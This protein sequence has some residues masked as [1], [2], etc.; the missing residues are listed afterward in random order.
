MIV[1]IGYCHE[2]Y[3][4]HENAGDHLDEDLG[5][6]MPNHYCSDWWEFLAAVSTLI[7]YGI[8]NMT[9]QHASII[10]AF[11][12][13]ELDIADSSEKEQ[14]HQKAYLKQNL[15]FMNN[16][17]LERDEDDDPST[18]TTHVHLL[19]AILNGIR[20]HAVSDRMRLASLLDA[21][22]EETDGINADKEQI[23]QSFHTC[24]NVLVDIGERILLQLPSSFVNCQ[25]AG[26][27]ARGL[28]ESYLDR[29]MIDEADSISCYLSQ[30]N[31][32]SELRSVIDPLR[33]ANAI[34]NASAHPLV[35]SHLSTSNTREQI[36]GFR[37]PRD[38]QDLVKGLFRRDLVD[39][40][41]AG[42]GYGDFLCWLHLPIYPEPLLFDYITNF[43]QE[44][45][46]DEEEDDEPS[47]EYQWVQDE[48]G[49][50]EYS[51]LVACYD[52]SLLMLIREWNKPWT[53][54]SHLSFSIPF[55]NAISSLALCAHRYGV[56][57]SIVEIVSS[58]LPRSWFDDERMCC[59]SHECQ[60]TQL[61]ELYRE[62]ISSRSSN[63][64]RQKSQQKTQNRGR[65]LRACGCEVAMVCCKDHWKK[66]QQE[67]HK[68]QCGLP[69][70]RP[71]FSKEENLFVR[72]I[73]EGSNTVDEVVDR[74]YDKPDP[75]QNVDDSDSWESV[76][77]NTED[78]QRCTTNDKIYSWFNSQSY[79]IQRRDAPAHPFADFY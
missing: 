73:F 1:L 65:T 4:E 61:S 37:P 11:F 7:G 29:T 2:T 9:N 48:I 31:T 49:F 76:D 27:V 57:A 66:L 22:D 42:F 64:N 10:C 8:D 24:V 16:E 6:N 74:E 18:T 53:P 13:R 35:S 67:G 60:M 3:I 34:T 54:R 71:P 23:C 79:K 33:Y 43:P 19:S 59:W 28:L 17:G 5:V 63:W 52:F 55:R 25:L 51:H 47:R 72:E 15:H 46:D 14:T 45:D 70:F 26:L 40:D 62:K 77:T 12:M 38:V 30:N 32:D 44:E 58:Y 69:P 39:L 78:V 41:I 68:R 36:I 21:T 20:L 50:M 75:N 56:P